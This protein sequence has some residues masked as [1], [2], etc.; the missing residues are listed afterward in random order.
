MRAPQRYEF[1]GL[2]VDYLIVQ[3]G[4]KTAGLTKDRQRRQAANLP[5]TRGFGE[6]E[7][8][9]VFQAGRNL[10]RK[11]HVD[12]MEGCSLVRQVQEEKHWGVP[13]YLWDTYMVTSRG[14]A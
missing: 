7:E 4:T 12:M 13:A 2:E 1:V 9:A 3:S 8:L 11:L 10:E 5:M 6:P 14:S